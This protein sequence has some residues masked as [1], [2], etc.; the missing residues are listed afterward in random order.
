MLEYGNQN[1]RIEVLLPDRLSLQPERAE[2]VS[3]KTDINKLTINIAGM[4]MVK[5]IISPSGIAFDKIV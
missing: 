3:S 4:I 2:S 5:G 1:L